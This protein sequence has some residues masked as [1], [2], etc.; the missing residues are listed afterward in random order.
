MYVR[1]GC[2]RASTFHVWCAYASA[3]IYVNVPHQNYPNVCIFI[4]TV[5][6]R[7]IA[8]ERAKERMRQRACTR[9]NNGTKNETYDEEVEA[10]IEAN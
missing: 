7:E 3:T 6:E 10:A 4:H 8:R 1:A 5:N 9:E 2:A